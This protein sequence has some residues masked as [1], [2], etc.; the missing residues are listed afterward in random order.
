MNE[1]RLREVLARK[2]FRR[3][4]SLGEVWTDG[5]YTV[6]VGANEILMVSDQLQRRFQ[7]AAGGLVLA[8][9]AVEGI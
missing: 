4:D 5:T 2:G 7:R 6:T 9:E 1:D 8:V 3:K